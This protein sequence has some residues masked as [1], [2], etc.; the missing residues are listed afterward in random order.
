MMHRF[1]KYIIDNLQKNIILSFIN[2]KKVKHKN[3]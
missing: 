3:L 1:A 2:D